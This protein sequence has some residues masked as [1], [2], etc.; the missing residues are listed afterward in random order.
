MRLLITIVAVVALASCSKRTVSTTTS[1]RDSIIIKEVVRV[2]TVKIPGETVT[3]R[4][5]IECDSLTNKPKPTSITVQKSKAKVSVR[6]D[7]AGMLTATG[8]CDS[9]EAVVK[10]LDKEV[11]HM[12]HEQKK[13]TITIT[14]YKTRGIDKFCRWFTGISLLLI[15]LIVVLKIY[16]II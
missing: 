3:I 4:E 2:D 9:L 12:R 6:I 13:E 8:G 5:Q 15:V 14:E 16:R 1:V 10:A 11:F 7:S